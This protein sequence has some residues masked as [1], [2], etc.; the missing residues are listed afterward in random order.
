MPQEIL[1]GEM[2]AWRGTQHRVARLSE[3]KEHKVFDWVKKT[4]EG[5][6]PLIL[7]AETM[8]IHW[9]AFD[10]CSKLAA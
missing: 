1:P 5:L 2:V 7:D 4:N 9:A 10:E 8:S 6:L 3:L